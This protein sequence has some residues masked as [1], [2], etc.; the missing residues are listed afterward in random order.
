MTSSPPPLRKYPELEGKTFLVGVGGTKCATSWIYSYLESLPEVSPSPLK[1]VHFFDA[2]SSDTAAQLDI[3]AMKR[4]AFHF[5]QDGDVIDNLRDRPAFQASVE[6][7][8]MIYDDNEYF[9]HFARLCTPDTRT[10]CDI[11]PAYSAIGRA[12]FQYMKE[13]VAFPA[14]S[15]SISTPEASSLVASISAAAP[16]PTPTT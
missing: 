12:G 4:L 9:A 15:I 7:V 3:F 10:V 5:R 1:E 16:Q 2:K 13:F 14:V 8:K 11:T 6:R